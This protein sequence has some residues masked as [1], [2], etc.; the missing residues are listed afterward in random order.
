LITVYSNFTDRF[1]RTFFWQLRVNPK[2]QNHQIIMLTV[3]AADAAAAADA[4]VLNTAAAAVCTAD[5]SVA[6]QQ[7]A[8]GPGNLP[9]SVAEGGS[10][11]LCAVSFLVCV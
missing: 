8:L 7:R 2:S 10:P 6:P 3:R 4:A 9:V 1:R 11:V 5:G